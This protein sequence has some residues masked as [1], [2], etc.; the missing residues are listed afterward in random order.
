MKSSG[1]MVL[2]GA[3]LG[4]AGLWF[5]TPVPDLILP[6]PVPDAEI[7]SRGAGGNVKKAFDWVQMLFNSVNTAFGALGTY[8]TYKGWCLRKADREDKEA[9]KAS[10]TEET[11]EEKA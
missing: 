2:G 11:S 3:M 4:V 1:F 7:A 6:A 10:A 5:L 9:K 8:F